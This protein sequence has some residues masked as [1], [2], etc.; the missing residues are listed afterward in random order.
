MAVGRSKNGTIARRILRKTLWVG[1]AGIC[2]NVSAGS[3]SPPPPKGN[4]QYIEQDTFSIENPSSDRAIATGIGCG[5]TVGEAEQ[6]ARDTSSFNLRRLTGSARYRIEF[7]RL[8]ETVQ[9]NKVCVELQARA[10]PPR[11]N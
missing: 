9:P 5:F 1:L 2:V 7:S 4:L 6:Y 8:N 10:V 3:C 11:L